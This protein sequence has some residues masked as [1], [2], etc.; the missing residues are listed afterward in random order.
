MSRKGQLTTPRRTIYDIVM[1]SSDHPTASEIMDR[2]KI[3]GCSF[4]YATV[5]NSLRYLTEEGMIR[6]LKLEGDASRYDARM[7]DHQHVLCNICGRLDEVL[8]EAPREWVDKIARA[9]GYSISEEQIL[10]K[11]ECPACKEQKRAVQ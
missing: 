6:E 3:R 5:Y 4:A 1:V 11:G 8:I 10:F 9:T 7:D 2:L